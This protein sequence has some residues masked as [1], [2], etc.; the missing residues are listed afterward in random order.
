M[1]SWSR[2]W[3]TSWGL[4]WGLTYEA[5]QEDLLTG[6]IGRGGK[7]KKKSSRVY[8]ERDGKILVFANASRAAS[9]VAAEKHAE[10]EKPTHT[11]A[12]KRAKKAEVRAIHQPVQEIAYDAI[13]A[14]VEQYSLIPD[15]HALI[16]RHEIDALMA[17]YAEAMRLQDEEDIELLLMAA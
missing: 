14:L 17:L 15:I 3:G 8:L 10:T 9:Y 12:P 16:R 4:S 2:A 7:G 11:I 6:G 1:N 13:A 5:N